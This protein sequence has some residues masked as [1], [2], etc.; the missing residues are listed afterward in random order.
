MFDKFFQ[1]SKGAMICNHFLYKTNL[2]P[3]YINSPDYLPAKEKIPKK[4]IRQ[5][6]GR[7]YVL[8]GDELESVYHEVCIELDELKLE[9][10][11]EILEETEQLLKGLNNKF[12][13]GVKAEIGFL[14]D[15][16][17]ASSLAIET[18][19]SMGLMNEN[20][21]VLNV[22]DFHNIYKYPE[23]LGRVKNAVEVGD[24]AGVE[25]LVVESIVEIGDIVETGD[26]SK[27]KSS[28]DPLVAVEILQHLKEC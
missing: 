6:Q 16:S 19:A 7:T 27:I 20:L 18:L 9:K 1:L 26:L 28:S 2:D 5:F 4:S 13:N 22:D 15:S 24:S 21:I 8:H 10:F 17:G 12:I 14:L 25:C 3:E 11:K 23:K